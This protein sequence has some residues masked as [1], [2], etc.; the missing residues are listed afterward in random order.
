MRLSFLHNKKIL[1]SI[2]FVWIVV[3]IVLIK[4]VFIPSVKFP[5]NTFPSNY[6]PT[7]SR[8]DVKTAKPLLVQYIKDNV[9]PNLLPSDFKSVTVLQSG[10]NPNL[11]ILPYA[12]KDASISAYL[13]HQNTGDIYSI[14]IKLTKEPKS[15]QP[16]ASS[17]TLINFLLSSYFIKPYVISGCKDNSGSLLCENFKIV[18]E[19]KI[20]YEVIILKAPKKI[21]TTLYTCQ[22][23]KESVDYLNAKSCIG[24]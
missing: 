1:Y 10:K 5:T 11:F 9:K 21:Y 7:V 13:H 17:T 6:T 4:I 23:A 22:I 24:Y 8:Y 14:S 16:F 12:T 15:K 2:V 18:P 3:L 20:G 19:G